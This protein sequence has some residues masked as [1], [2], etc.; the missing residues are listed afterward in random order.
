MSE[1]FPMSCA[2]SSGP[3]RPGQARPHRLT[4]LFNVVG[5]HSQSSAPAPP[6]PPRPPGPA[7]PRPP[8][9]ALDRRLKYSAGPDEN[10]MRTFVTVLTVPAS[11][12]RGD[13]RVS[14]LLRLD[15]L[16][17]LPEHSTARLA[18]LRQHR[19][20]QRQSRLR[21]DWDQTRTRFG[22]APVPN[23]RFER[24][25]MASDFENSS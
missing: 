5:T 19:P 6:P 9:P 10:V 3:A 16:L 11:P 13:E 17:G 24:T 2:G 23:F 22:S 1:M 14:V 21:P 15:L 18:A 7:P 4:V 8:A 25:L 12:G 20:T